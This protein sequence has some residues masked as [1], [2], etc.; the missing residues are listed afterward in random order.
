MSDWSSD[1]C[2]SDLLQLAPLRGRGSLRLLM[3]IGM[4]IV[5]ALT[6]V[7]S[8]PLS[9]A[10]GWLA[11]A[12]AFALWS[13]GKFNRMRPADPQF[14]GMAEYPLCPRQARKRVVWGKSVCVRVCFVG[15]R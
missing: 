9:V 4:A 8:V 11:C 7:H 12:L 2:S 1:V 10:G 15:R 14:P 6:M 3:G 13:Y 5:A